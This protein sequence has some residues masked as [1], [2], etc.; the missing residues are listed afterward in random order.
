MLGPGEARR[1]TGDGAMDFKVWPAHTLEA[2]LGAVRQLVRSFESTDDE[3]M[4]CKA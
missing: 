3:A 1:S 2:K 4:G